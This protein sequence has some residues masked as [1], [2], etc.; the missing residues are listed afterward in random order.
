M[1]MLYGAV[2]HLPMLRRRIC[3]HLLDVFGKIVFFNLN[4]NCS[5]WLIEIPILI[6]APTKTQFK[7]SYTQF[8]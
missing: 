6:Y 8:Y 7:M 2:K 3:I 1:D 4:K 5:V